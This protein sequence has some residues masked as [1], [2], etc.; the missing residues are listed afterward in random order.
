MDL[1]DRI[2]E[3]AKDAI[4]RLNLSNIE[5]DSLYPHQDSELVTV[6]FFEGTSPFSVEIVLGD[7]PELF[8]Q[9][10]VEALT[11]QIAVELRKRQE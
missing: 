3:A 11:D 2:A 7:H 6:H 8:A 5:Y 4:V 1:H 9:T 10:S